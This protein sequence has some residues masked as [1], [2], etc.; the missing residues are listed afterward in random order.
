MLEEQNALSFGGTGLAGAWTTHAEPPTSRYSGKTRVIDPAASSWFAMNHGSTPMPTPATTA[1][2]TKR[3]SS[4]LTRPG[5]RT[6]T[7]PFGR[8]SWY[9]TLSPGKSSRWSWS[10]S[11]PACLGSAR[12]GHA[13]DAVGL[14]RR[15]LRR[16]RPPSATDHPDVLRGDGRRVARPRQAAPAR[17]VGEAEPPSNIFAQRQAGAST[18]EAGA[19]HYRFDVVL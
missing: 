17:C 2:R 12:R 3:K 18:L 11:S 7:A 19:T 1:P 10:G 5:T 14:A 8:S 4:P 15:P 9:T 6:V 16:A 13:Q